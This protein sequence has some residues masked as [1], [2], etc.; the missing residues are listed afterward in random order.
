MI[1]LNIFSTVYRHQV[2]VSHT[3]LIISK[4]EGHRDAKKRIVLFEAKKVHEFSG[5]AKNGHKFELTTSVQLK[6]EVSEYKRS[7]QRGLIRLQ[8]WL[9][10]WISY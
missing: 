1:V 10:S 2:K 6:K 8:Q 9:D 4:H 5:E 7:C 3:A